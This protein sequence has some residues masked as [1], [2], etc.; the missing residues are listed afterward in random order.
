MPKQSNTE[1]ATIGKVVALFGL[2]GELKVRTFTDIPNRFA[3]LDAVYV[4]DQYTRH[5]IEG[6]RP[7]KGDM[8]LLKLK[9]FDDATSAEKLRGVDLS[10]PLSKL[11]KLP[12]DSYYQHDII[13]LR[14]FT[15]DDKLLG[16]IVDIIITGSNDVYV[17]KMQ[18]GTQQ[19]IPAIKDVI[20]QIDL[21][22]H[23][24]HIDPIPG[25]LDNSDEQDREE[26]DATRQESE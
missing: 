10:I 21:L 15:L 19:L 14:A 22:R 1:W 2:R 16:T 4:G 7:Y 8:I 25:L 24:M 20:K 23:T 26:A 5:I 9:G 18:D 6:V 12:P 17:V 13:G 3:E 11:A